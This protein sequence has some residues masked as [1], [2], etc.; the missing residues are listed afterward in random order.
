MDSDCWPIDT[1]RTDS[2]IPNGPTT[3]TDSTVDALS[4]VAAVPYGPIAATVS[5]L[6]ITNGTRLAT[7]AGPETTTV[8]AVLHGHTP[9]SDVLQEQGS[10][11]DP[12]S[13]SEA[14]QDRR[15]LRQEMDRRW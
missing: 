12:S 10:R 6:D 8:S 15:P 7:V 11:C 9:S 1:A 5:T 4:V 2:A 14:Q 13:T 3:A